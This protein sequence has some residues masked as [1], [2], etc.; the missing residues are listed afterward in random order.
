MQVTQC[1]E[2][3]REMSD[4]GHGPVDTRLRH[5]ILVD[6][7]SRREAS[8]KHDLNFRT[9]QKI[10]K[11]PE[12]PLRPKEYE[13]AKP[14]IG[15]FVSVI[16]EILEADKK[17]HAKQRHTGRRLFE[18]LR[19]EHGYTGGITGVRDEIRRYKQSTQEVFMPLFAC[20]W[21]SPVRFRRGKGRLSWSSDEGDV[22]CD[23]ASLQRRILLSGVSP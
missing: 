11:A 8:Q 9:I 12:P 20:A 16:H 21:R 2:S 7:M 17:V 13:R 18:R 6:G 5:D 4:Y 1:L 10:L 22:L 23:V 15:P 19:D 14:K 3:T